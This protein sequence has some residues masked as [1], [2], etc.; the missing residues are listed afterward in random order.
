VIVQSF[1]SLNST[2]LLGVI[3]SLSNI[4]T[5]KILELYYAQPHGTDALAGSPELE[6]ICFKFRQATGL[7]LTESQMLAELIKLRKSGVLKARDREAKKVVKPTWPKFDG[8]GFVV[9]IPIKISS[10]KM[11]GIFAHM[12]EMEN[13]PV[14]RQEVYDYIIENPHALENELDLSEAG[15]VRMKQL[16]PEFKGHVT[17]DYPNL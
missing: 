4:Q 2:F 9:N 10:Y 3:M 12:E 17:A 13:L 15:E 6:D 5:N 16:F 1:G 11:A 7:K 14:T 8:D